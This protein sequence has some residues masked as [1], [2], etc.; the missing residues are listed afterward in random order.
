M[1]STFSQRLGVILIGVAVLSSCSRPVAYFQRGYVDP[2]SKSAPQTIAVAAP[3]QAIDQPAESLTQANQAIT[4]IDAYVRNDNKLSSNKT[5]TG[6]MARVKNLLAS[7][8]KG[9]GVSVM[10]A[11]RKMSGVERLMLKKINKRIGQQLAPNNPEKAMGNRVHLI[12]GIVL[13]IGG[14]I[15]LI[16]G[17]GTAAFIGLIVALIGALGLILGLFGE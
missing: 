12:G 1:T 3:V 15:L 17:T 9:F 8:N 5:L 13:L 2:F 10:N 4:Q 16:A 6:R 11:P 7:T 14:L